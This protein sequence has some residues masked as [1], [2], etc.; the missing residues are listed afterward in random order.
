VETVREREREKNESEKKQKESEIEMEGERYREVWKEIFKR[1]E[2]IWERQ[3]GNSALQ[4]LA[5]VLTL[6]CPFDL[7]LLLLV[8]FPSQ[9][10]W[11]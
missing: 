2:K 8:L 5:Q 10:H 11:S 7:L 3:R 1:K 6:F 4:I 9:P